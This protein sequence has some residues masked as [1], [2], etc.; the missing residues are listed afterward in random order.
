VLERAA[1]FWQTRLMNPPDSVPKADEKRSRFPWLIAAII[2]VL[3]AGCLIYAYG[4]AIASVLATSPL[5]W[6]LVALL[7]G[8]ALA[9]RFQLSEK[10]QNERDIIVTVFVLM[11]G[12]VFGLYLASAAADFAPKTSQA[13]VMQ[14]A[15]GWSLGYFSLGFVVGFL[16]G[17]PR[18][19]QAEGNRKPGAE[20][21]NY[22]QRVNTNL[23]QISD[24]LTK[25]IVGLGLVQ[26]RTVPSH[27]QKAAQW[28]AESFVGPLAAG[29]AP[30][31]AAT[32]FA[33]A[34]II[35][36]TVLGFLGGYL[37]TRLFLAGAFGRADRGQIV[38]EPPQSLAEV[39]ASDSE[40]KTNIEK[41]RNYWKPSGIADPT[42]TAEIEK[43]LQEKGRSDVKLGDLIREP[44]HA[45][46]R[47]AA[48]IKFNL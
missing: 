8:F 6:A 22:E 31:E 1:W 42:R 46:L 21:G 33:G 39:G 41:L 29:T 10:W 11:A 47:K 30:S 28:M 34:L 24:W 16:F 36:F 17:I 45:D 40:D 19:L 48:V 25:I 15:M 26:L 35:F 3:L 20:G 13:A 37:T 43:W 27:L 23:E 44:E 32:S 18:V 2:A 7:I 4:A 38:V 14:I 12:L 5:V 9:W